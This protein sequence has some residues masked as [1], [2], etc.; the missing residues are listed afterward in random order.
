MY[1]KVL[2][3]LSELQEAIE[4]T[5]QGHIE[6]ELGDVF[7]SLINYARFL[8]VDADKALESCNQKFIK[9]FNL[10]EQLAA[11][12][13][14]SIT[15]PDMLFKEM[16]DLWEAAKQK[17]KKELGVQGSINGDGSQAEQ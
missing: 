1:D 6:E 12:Q 13:G 9:R 3:E 17:L 14:R 11:D 7:F 8:K 16:D 2:E 10:M 15:D 4:S 5:D